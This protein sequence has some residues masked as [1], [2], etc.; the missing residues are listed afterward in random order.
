MSRAGH[1]DLDV[2]EALCEVGIQ[3]GQLIQRAVGGTLLVTQHLRQEEWCEGH[4]H[5]NALHTEVA[6]NTDSFFIKLRP[7]AMVLSINFSCT[8]NSAPSKEVNPEKKET[9]PCPP[10]R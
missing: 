8:T 5:H 7:E 2:A 9:I 10:H 1:D 4:L 3:R 6:H